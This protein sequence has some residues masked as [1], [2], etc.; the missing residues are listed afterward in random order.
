MGNLMNYRH[1]KHHSLALGI[2]HKI[3]DLAKL[4]GTVKGIYDTSRAVYSI[5]SA[6]APYVLPLLG[7]L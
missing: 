6:A 7:A 4:A 3:K 1:D 5:A 2:G